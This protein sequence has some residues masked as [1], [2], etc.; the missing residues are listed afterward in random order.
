MSVPGT[1]TLEYMARREPQEEPV[2]TIRLRAVGGPHNGQ[3]LDVQ[4]NLREGDVHRE[5][6]QQRLSALDPFSVPSASDITPIA[7]Y[8]LKHI[9][10]RDDRSL[11]SQRHEVLVHESMSLFDAISYA[12]SEWGPQQAAEEVVEGQR[13]FEHA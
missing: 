11:E 3:W 9:H 7:Y 13:V 5:Y 1:T 4:S 12:L 10:F 8:R 2:S 6:V